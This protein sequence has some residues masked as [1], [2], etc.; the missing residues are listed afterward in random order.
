VAERQLARQPVELEYKPM[1][2]RAGKEKHWSVSGIVPD[3]ATGGGAS[4]S[5]AA[6]GE[7]SRRLSAIL[8]DL[9]AGDRRSGE[10]RRVE[11]RPVADERRS[12]EDRRSD[13]QAA[14]AATAPAGRPQLTVVPPADQ[15]ASVAPTTVA[16]INVDTADAPVTAAYVAP[17]ENTS[18]VDARTEPEPAFVPDPVM[19]VP[20]ASGDSDSAVVSEADEFVEAQRRAIAHRE[21]IQAM[22]DEARAVEERLVAEAREARE[23]R[24][25]LGV[26]EKIALVASLVEREQQA[27][28][29]GRDVMQRAERLVAEHAQAEDEAAA[30]RA[31]IDA[32]TAAVVEC[33]RRL[34]EARRAVAD[35]EA[36]ANECEDRVQ[37]AAAAMLQSQREAQETE[38][39]MAECR[40]A[41]EASEADA[42][43]AQE[44]AKSLVPSATALEL[45]HSL[46]AVVRGRSLSNEGEAAP[47]DA[48]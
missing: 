42:R 34:A 26:E 22:L 41:R 18:E 13:V 33:Q 14:S 36:H 40:A 23:I 12:G 5:D 24:A 43:S 7:G 28:A 46:E 47:Q 19:S 16:T 38:R 29:R 17:L 8:A 11:V 44:R 25:R 35:S 27:A 10:E 15:V 37:R 45:L 48:A 2:F 30:S 3:R 1:F 20:A 9:D 6:A 31:S 39:Q 32:A 21:A 4:E